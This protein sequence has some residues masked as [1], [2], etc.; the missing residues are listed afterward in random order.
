MTTSLDVVQADL[1]SAFVLS[2]AVCYMAHSLAFFALSSYAIAVLLRAIFSSNM[3]QMPE[4]QPVCVN[5]ILHT[6]HLNQI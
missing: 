3:A 6:H 4:L 5:Q 1:E 2:F